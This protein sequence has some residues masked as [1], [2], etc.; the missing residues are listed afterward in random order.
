VGIHLP[1]LVSISVNGQ[2]ASL[3]D[4]GFCTTRNAAQ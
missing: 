4:P 1:N 3:N 2:R